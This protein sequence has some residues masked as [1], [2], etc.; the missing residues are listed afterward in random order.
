MDSYRGSIWIWIQISIQ[1]ASH[2][3][4]WRE[5]FFHCI[6]VYTLSA[7]LRKDLR[8]KLINKLKSSEES[9]HSWNWNAAKVSRCFRKGYRCPITMNHFFGL[10]EKIKIEAM[11]YYYRPCSTWSHILHLNWFLLCHRAHLLLI[12]IMHSVSQCGHQ[13]SFSTTCIYK[14]GS[15]IL[16][17]PSVQTWTWVTFCHHLRA[18]KI[19]AFSRP[20]L[21]DCCIK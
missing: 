20:N 16:E 15:I 21:V 12:L 17:C 7:T 4:R 18:K 6:F 14:K 10:W 5:E 13:I 2:Y 19:E 9:D 8:A 11:L 3:W 1:S